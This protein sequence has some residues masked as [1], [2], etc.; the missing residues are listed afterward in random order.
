[1]IKISYGILT[2]DEGQYIETL[3]DFLCSN[4]RDVDEIVVVDDFSSDDLT[5]EILN[6]YS[7]NK[8]VQLHYR[9]FDG[10]HTQK[11]YL[12]SLCIG[13]Y[14]VQLDADELLHPEFIEV[15]PEILEYNDVDLYLVPRINT[16]DGLTQTDI[17]R[18][19]WNVNEYGWVNFPDFQM[20]IYKNLTDIRWEGLLH[21]KIVGARKI[22]ELPK[23][24]VYCILHH[25]KIDRQRE[26][27]DLYEKIEKT[28]RTKYKIT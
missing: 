7:S 15:L 8:M 24:P 2:H 11:N 17:D 1:M 5:K 9:V 12:N 27:N 10:D 28:G 3:L 4:K 21:S 25:K 16:I 26:Q 6:K 19:G 22:A 18:W 14:I 23:E 13:D 20:R